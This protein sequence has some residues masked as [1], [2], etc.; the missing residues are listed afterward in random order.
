MKIKNYS[1]SDNVNGGGTVHLRKSEA[2]TNSFSVQ[3]FPSDAIR[4]IRVLLD[5]Y[6]TDSAAEFLPGLADFSA[7]LA[8]IRNCLGMTPAIG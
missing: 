3:F 1:H 4:L 8:E 2:F 7:F 5:Q 6:A